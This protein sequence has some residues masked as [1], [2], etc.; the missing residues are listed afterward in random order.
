[1]HDVAQNFVGDLFLGKLRNQ[2]WIGSRAFSS[3]YFLTIVEDL[4]NDSTADWLRE[5]CMRKGKCFCGTLA[6]I[7]T[8]L[9]LFQALTMSWVLTYFV[10][11]SWISHE[12]ESSSQVFSTIFS[13]LFLSALLTSCAHIDRCTDG[14]KLLYLSLCNQLVHAQEVFLEFSP[15]A[16]GAREPQ[17]GEHK[18]GS[19]EKENLKG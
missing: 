18:S 6:S 7:I 12:M 3:Q 16:R 2:A 19:G 1:M 5:D 4:F 13:F 14:H 10:V 17:S 11:Q 15:H 9:F 8:K